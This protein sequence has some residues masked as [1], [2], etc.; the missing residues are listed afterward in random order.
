MKQKILITLITILLIIGSINVT[1]KSIENENLKNEELFLTPRDE[2]AIPFTCTIENGKFY[3]SFERDLGIVEISIS[4]VGGN[5][6]ANHSIDSSVG[7]AT[8]ILP[9]QT[10]YYQ[11]DIIT[12]EEIYTG[13]FIIN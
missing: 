4:A 12:N 7:D 11:I 2:E 6:V 13:N 9:E 3:I 5:A 1:A 8:I 10:G